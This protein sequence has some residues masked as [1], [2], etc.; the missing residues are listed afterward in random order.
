MFNLLF[1]HYQA[2]QMASPLS[3]PCIYGVST[4]N[5]WVVREFIPDTEGNPCIYKGLPLH[6]EYRV[7]VDCD[8]RRVIGAT[9]YW[10]PDTMKKRFGHSSD[11]DSPHQIHDYV[12]YL[13]HEATLMDRYNNNIQTVLAHI[14]NEVLPNLNLN[15]QWSIDIMQNGDDFCLTDIALAFAVIPIASC[16]RNAMQTIGQIA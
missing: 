5:E 1:I 9:P 8:T 3:K 4:T 10:E 6:T 14:E 12:V 13:A 16:M 11:S 7:F 15:R 2:L